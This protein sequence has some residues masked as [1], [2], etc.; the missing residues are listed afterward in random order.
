MGDLA[1]VKMTIAMNELFLQIQRTDVL[2]KNDRVAPVVIVPVVDEYS[3]FF[4]HLIVEL[5][6]RYGE[7][8]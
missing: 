1:A 5:S 7:E 3:V 6:S 8:N 2:W 4:L